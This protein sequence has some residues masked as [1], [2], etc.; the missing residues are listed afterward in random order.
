LLNAMLK[1]YVSNPYKIETDIT[2][3]MP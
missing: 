3:A 2:E 1:Y